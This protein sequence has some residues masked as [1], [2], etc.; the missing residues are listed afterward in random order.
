M[1][2]KV[3]VLLQHGWAWSSAHWSDWCRLAPEGFA[4]LSLDRGYFGG[5]LEWSA[6]GD[7][8]APAIA[9]A[10]SLGLHLLP[11][12]ILRDVRLLVVAGGFRGFHGEDAVAASRSRRRVRS[13]LQRLLHDPEEV[14][15]RFYA[16]CSFPEESLLQVPD[17]LDAGALRR[18]LQLLD[19]SELD[20]AV[21]A[22]LPSVLLLHG[23]ADRVV[24][25]E[26]ARALHR[27]LPESALR[28]VDGAGHALPVT[29]VT[30]CW[31]AIEQAWNG[32]SQ[33]CG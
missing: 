8:A 18:D 6:A 33:S 29:H 12:D 15:R 17:E 2:G 1:T 22:S 32:I 3:E 27:Q 16:E 28:V 9:V 20:L 4:F 30:E 21:L 31:Q 13:M 25:V 11:G 5:P 14:L 10:H 24:P 7:R 19:E 26:R 23:A